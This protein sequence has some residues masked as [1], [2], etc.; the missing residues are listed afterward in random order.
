MS[1][2]NSSLVR[3]LIKDYLKEAKMMQLATVS[4]GKPWV[5]NVWFA[6]DKN[7]NVYWFSATNR[8]HSIEVAKDSHVAAAIC[9]PQTSSDKPRGIQLEG[10]AELVAKPTEVA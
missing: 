3:K 10:T 9:L 7:L 2:K 6:A 4:N 8:R 1:D 5:C